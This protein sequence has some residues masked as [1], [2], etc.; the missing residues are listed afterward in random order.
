M[1][2]TV[3][4]LDYPGAED[5]WGLPAVI[6]DRMVKRLYDEGFSIL[7]IASI[8][9]SPKNR[10][11]DLILDGIPRRD[12]KAMRRDWAE[13]GR[14]QR[15]WMDEAEREAKR[16]ESYS[17]THSRTLREIRKAAWDQMDQSGPLDPVR[18]ALPLPEP[19]VPELEFGEQPPLE[20]YPENLRGPA[21][22]PE[23]E[24]QKPAPELVRDRKGVLVDGE[25]FSSAGA[26]AK[27]IGVSEATIGHA[28][29]SGATRLRTGET[30]ALDDPDK[31]WRRVN[32]P[33]ET[34][35]TDEQI[36]AALEGMNRGYSLHAAAREWRI[37]QMILMWHRRRQRGFRGRA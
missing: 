36:E 23:P 10:I 14:T 16:G 22:E 33:P 29:R 25:W 12:Q 32:V 1:S 7:E 6:D 18:T 8:T 13:V 5:Y 34:D 15:K 26:A 20:W 21:P 35:A 30:V 27:A 2:G 4:N 9:G 37:P 11:A 31:E 28:L 17:V 3:W 24:I 19:P